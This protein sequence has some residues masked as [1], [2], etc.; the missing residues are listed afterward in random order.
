SIRSDMKMLRRIAPTFVKAS[1]AEMRPYMDE[2]EHKLLEESNYELELKNSQEF[3][4]ACQHLPGIYFPQYLPQYSSQRVITMSWI[5]GVHLRDFLKTASPATRTQAA[6]T[7]WDFYEYQMHVLKKLN[8]DPHPGNF[9]FNEKGEV[10]V[11]DF[12]CTKALSNELYDD[13]FD[14][15]RKGLFEDKVETERILR[16]IQ[17][18]RPEDKPAKV[19]QLM[20]LFSRMIGLVTQPYHTGTF[21]FGEKRFFEQVNEI[22]IEISKTREVRGSR[23]FL[24]INRTYFGLFALFQQMEVVLETGCKY[25]DF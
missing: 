7:I 5:E 3:A 24:F 12:G 11:L 4:T 10:G 14:L 2:V 22:G 25:R 8:A 20:S 21:N 17:I 16:K 6:Q 15:A 18:L 9:L 23:E 13:Y 19:D 1:A